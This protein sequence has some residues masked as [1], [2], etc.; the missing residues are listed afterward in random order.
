MNLNVAE[1]KQ[2]MKHHKNRIFFCNIL[3]NKYCYAKGP[4]KRF[5]LN[6]NTVGFQPL[7]QKLEVHT[8]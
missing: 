4:P 6:G 3:R 7:T 1:K 2:T 8:K 5:H